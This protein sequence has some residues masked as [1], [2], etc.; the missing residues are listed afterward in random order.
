MNG[1][2]EARALKEAKHKRARRKALEII[3]S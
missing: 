1:P 3:S 2:D